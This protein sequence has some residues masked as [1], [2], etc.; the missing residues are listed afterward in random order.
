[1]SDTQVEIAG[2]SGKR[3]LAVS[4]GG[5][6]WVQLG[7]LRPAF[8]GHH[9][10]FVTVDPLYASDVPGARFHVVNDATR[11]NKLGLVLLALRITLILLRT[12]PD[13]V[14]STGAAP[15]YLAL[16]IGK[17]LGRRTI[18]VDSVANVEEL[19]LSGRRVGKHADL[20]LTQW[21]HLERPA[22]PRYMGSV[23]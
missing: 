1:M 11:W 10:T 22:G 8:D 17:L 15:G 18:W 13:V 3:I 21:P 16:R 7:R 20:W 5:G 9:V 6:H 12:R 2:A 23:L 4:S 14:L 19:S